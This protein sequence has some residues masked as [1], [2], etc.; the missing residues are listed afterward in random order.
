MPYSLALNSM[1]EKSFA[2]CHAG[3]ACPALDVKNSIR[4]PLC[5]V[6]SQ[7]MIVIPWD[8]SKE[9]RQ[10]IFVLESST[11]KNS[12]ITSAIRFEL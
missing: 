2:I 12:K 6:V 5:Q 3:L 9:R 8:T 11:Y 1:W 4:S 7:Y 10:G